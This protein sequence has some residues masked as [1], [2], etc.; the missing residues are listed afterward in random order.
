M[1]FYFIFA[2]V[3]TTGYKNNENY[4]R[5]IVNIGIFLILILVLIP[6][7]SAWSQVKKPAKI[8]IPAAKLA[9][10]QKA[11]STATKDSTNLKQTIKISKDSIDAPV[12]YNAEDSGVMIMAT[13]EFF[14]YGNALTRYKTSKLEAA[15]I[16]Y[17]Q[18][19]QNIKAY[20]AKDTTG[21]PLSNPKFE[22][23]DVTSVNDSIY[24]NM[25]S[26]KGLTK[27]T[28]FQQGE[29]FVNAVTMKKVNK[30]EAFAYRARF[31]TC[32][33]DEPHF[34][35]RTNKLKIITDKIGVS[36]PTFPEFEGVPFPIG[37]PF[38]I[39]PLAKGRHS[40]FMAPAFSTS[41]DFG[42]GFEGLGYYKVLS[43]NF[44]ATVR[45]N[46]YSYG[47]WN[48]NLNSK[49]ILRYKF[50]GNFN[51]SMQNTR[52]LNRNT[53]IDAEYTGGRTFMIN[54][55]HSMDQRA[56]PGT[57]FN[58]NVNFGSTKYNKLLLNNPFQ[59][60][61]NQISSSISYNKTWDNKYN[62]SVNLNH[63]QNNN[64][65]LVNMSLPNINFNAI[66]IYPFQSK[67]QIGSGKW[68]EK[69]GIGYNGSF[70]NQFSFYDSAFNINRLLD[71]MQWGAQHSIPIS[72]SLPS[73]GPVTITPGVSF[74]EKWFGQQNTRTWN[75]ATKRVDTTINRGFYRAPHMSFSLGTSTRIFGTYKFKNSNIKA[76]RH[77]IRPTMSINYT[78]DLAASYHY[79]TQIDTS[80][81]KYRFSKYD[82]GGLGG[83]YSEG[84]FGGMGFGIDNLLEMKVKDKG[85][86]SAEAFKKVKLI[87]GFGFNSSYNFL[88]DSFA[89]SNFNIYVRTTLFDKLNITSNLTL[90][91]YQTD[92]KGFRVNKF[93]F[94]PTKMKF[95]SVT[96]GGLS[97]STS[98]KSKETKETKTKEIPIDPFMTP[99]EQQRQLQYAKSNPAEFT[100]FNIP[101]TLTVS[102]S[103]QF[104]RTI[105][106]DYT[107]FQI[108]TYS[109]LNFNGD[110]S[111]TP[112]WKLGGTGYIDVAK[113]NIQQLSMF[114]TREMHCWQL[115]INV[116]PIGLYKS[117]SITVNPKSGILR[118]LK[119]NRSRTFSST[120]Y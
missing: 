107:G 109:S 12:D 15:N 61:Q 96:S 87:E 27:N 36:G 64:L 11:D 29:I 98:F 8:S 51:L 37:I 60:Y 114:I 30:D 44:D 112:K 88:A 89:L 103:F 101:W 18:L 10:S 49:Y 111:I 66:T 7:V 1:R 92:N 117:F 28:Y 102:Y 43:D 48:L 76:I 110:F 56:R 23:G 115:A 116:T 47:G 16:V 75:N 86:T 34:A 71:T 55:S 6:S 58:A 31:T 82:G 65:G 13:K 78:P 24:F 57:S 2:P 63:S 3:K 45:S 83:A 95:G 22:E 20:G 97:F 42:L 68:Y 100:D 26:G 93:N 73:L 119:I 9:P 79:T 94:D 70:Q 77:E 105:K 39:F 90:D 104:N 50:M 80:G 106:P 17:D 84:T 19:S 40:G 41:E 4:S 32:N 72:L 91:P 59:N 53:S 120:T 81:R 35:F 113:G 62:L 5:S 99:D 67:D 14:L 25:K 46:I 118:D 52:M 69:L 33:L 54:W 38:G 108:N 85:D 21:S 74:E